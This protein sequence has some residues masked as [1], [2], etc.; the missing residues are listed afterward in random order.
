LLVKVFSARFFAQQ[1]V[2]TPVKIALVSMAT[3]LLAALLLIVPFQH[4]G[5]ALATALATWMNAGLLY[6]RL[7]KSGALVADD[8]LKRRFPRLLLCAAGMAVVTLFVVM[9]FE[10]WYVASSLGRKIAAL[11]MIIGS[12]TLAYAALLHVTGAM[13][14][15]DALALI[16]PHKADRQA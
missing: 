15:R 14:W 8:T 10:N 5:I 13:R 3:N 7:R 6:L 16:R 2:R 4:V 11:A 1:D 12:S 9:L